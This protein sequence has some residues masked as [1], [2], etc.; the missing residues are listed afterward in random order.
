MFKMRGV[1][2]LAALA[3]VVLL[4]FP[5]AYGQRRGGG[6]GGR[7]GGGGAPPKP[8]PNTN[9]TVIADR[10]EVSQVQAEMIKLNKQ[11]DTTVNTMTA[12]FHKTDDYIA[13][14][15]VLDDANAELTVSREAAMK[16]LAA[17]PDYKAAKEKEKAAQ[18]K[19]NDMKSRNAAR[20]LIAVQSSEVLKLGGITSKLEREG[21]AADP[22]YSAA[23]KKVADATAA[24]K[25]VN[26]QLAEQIKANK[27]I[28]DLK[29]QQTEAK[30]KL[31]D[32]NKRLAQDFASASQ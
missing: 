29:T 23:Q 6:G 32:A 11:I 5:T 17:Q 15:K 14:K 18:A 21:L 1:L 20:D 28:T 30:A 22:V 12:D 4:P 25:V 26:D 31:A 10:A 2:V 8:D 19:L 3:L 27:E 13:A 9:P 16:K 7:G 24:M